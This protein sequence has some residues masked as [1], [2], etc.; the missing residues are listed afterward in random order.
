M[1]MLQRTDSKHP[2]FIALVKELD[3]Y[4]KITDGD[5]HDFYNQFNGIEQ[6]NHVIVAYINDVAVGCGAFKAY[7]STSVEIKR[8][9]TSPSSRSK[10][11]ASK[12]LNELENWA[13][14]LNFQSAVLETGK[15]QVEAVKF[16]KKCDYRSIPKYGQYKDMDNSLCFEKKLMKNEKG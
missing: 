3:D 10:G 13:S 9:F 7:D 8:M 2:E 5:E 1:I 14:E 6:L 11:V 15:R 4:L 16:Y 12:I